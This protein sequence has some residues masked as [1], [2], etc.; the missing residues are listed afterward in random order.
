MSFLN[1]INSVSSAEVVE[2]PIVKLV[3]LEQGKKFKIHEIKAVNGKFGEVIVVE[4]DDFKVFLPK[5]C[6]DVYK[7]H[8]K[9]FSEGTYFLEFLGIQE[10]PKGLKPR[11]LFKITN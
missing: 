4:L 2:K 1:E 6:S 5:R 3:D 7:K 10:L 9:E 8:L 11:T